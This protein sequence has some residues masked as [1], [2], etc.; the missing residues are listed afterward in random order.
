[1]EDLL[2]VCPGLVYQRD[3]RDRLHA[4]EPHQVDL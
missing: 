1:M 4:G 3:V 2:L